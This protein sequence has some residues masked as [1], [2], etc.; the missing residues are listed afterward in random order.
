[1]LTRVPAAE[2]RLRCG[3]HA[4][5]LATAILARKDASYR[6]ALAKF[7]EDQ[8][9]DVLAHPDPRAEKG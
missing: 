8:T 4:G 2:P 9:N 7:R 3:H 5:L 6:A 1:M